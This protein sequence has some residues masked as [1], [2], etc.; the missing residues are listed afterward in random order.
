VSLTG[1]AVTG[2]W[3]VLALPADV[4][5]LVGGSLWLGGL[6]MLIVVALPLATPTALD[7]IVPRY[8]TLAAG[9]VIAIVVSSVFQSIRQVGTLHAL[10]ST[11]YGQL[12]LVKLA[13][14][15]LIII[16]AA[17]SRDV[18]RRWYRAPEAERLAIEADFHADDVE[19]GSA[20]GSPAP[21]GSAPVA[22]LEPPETTDT[23]AEWARGRL[24][25][26][27]GLEVVLLV[28]VLIVTSLLVDARP[29]YETATGPVNITMKTSKMWF[30]VD[31]DPG[32]AGPNQV[33]VYALTPTGGVA[34][35]LDLSMEMT[36]KD[37][38]VGPLKVPLIRA[39][40]GHD[41]TQGF[42]IP[43]SGSWQ[44]TVTALVDQ[45][46]EVNATQTVSI[47]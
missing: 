42:Q 8:S 1:H 43:F 26:T 45:L 7:R 28:V 25:R 2:R 20:G 6:V 12:L 14:F 5:H 41:L 38:N 27:A 32:R 9:S 37:H 47:H 3:R 4:L 40:P 19:L 11:T 39:A 16:V 10:T 30:N 44:I 23:P 18:V 31:I 35:P 46:D 21:S 34:D 36:N 22:L 15:T 33:H 13:A 24:L 17:L 29:A